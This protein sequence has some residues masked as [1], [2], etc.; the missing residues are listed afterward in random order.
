MHRDAGPAVMVVDG[1][2]R[3]HP[4]NGATQPLDP[5]S[6]PNDDVAHAQPLVAGHGI[7]GQLVSVANAKRGDVDLFSFVEPS[8]GA[9]GGFDELKL[10]LT[11]TTVAVGANGGAA[12]DLALEVL[13]GDGARILTVDDAGPG[14]PE[15]YPNLGAIP[16]HSYY[17]RVLGSSHSSSKGA[18]L[19]KEGGY[20][21]TVERQA[22]QAG[23]ELE[24]NDKAQSATL[25]LGGDGHGFFGRRRDEDWL[26]VPTAGGSLLKLEVG[27]I[28]GVAPKLRVV[29][30]AAGAVVLA[31]AES[32]R[33]GELR[34]RNVGLPA[35][36]TEVLV[37]LTGD[38]KNPTTLWQLRFGVE[39]AL[40]GAEREP[41]DTLATATPIED[42]VTM[43]GFLWP[44][45]ID[46]YCTAKTAGGFT[47]SLEGVDGVDLKLDNVVAAASG[48]VDVVARA[49]AH[50]A[51]QGEELPLTPRGADGTCYRVTGRSHDTAFEAPYRLTVRPGP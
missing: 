33:G 24:P 8:G 15:I 22:A 13:D 27:G 14:E 45:D 42:G 46:Y 29:T 7:A 49:D 43:S 6:E 19:A 1:H 9:D 39:A 37:Q 41:N 21:L 11:P 17:V 23:A 25:L 51:G 3:A 35:G 31:K 16:G 47:V 34:L 18:P 48:K 32:G 50:K 5:E 4:V 36:S 10:T 44:G 30:D 20:S 40:D 12:L 28:E 2:E 26:R 38:G